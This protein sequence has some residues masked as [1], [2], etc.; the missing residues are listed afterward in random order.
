MYDVTHLYMKRLKT[1]LLFDARINNNKVIASH[2][3]CHCFVK[4]Y[5]AM[6]HCYCVCH[7]CACVIKIQ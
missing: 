7:V 2:G 1:L 6:C 5:S 3:Q 4:D